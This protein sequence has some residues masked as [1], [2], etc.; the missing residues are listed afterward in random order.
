MIPFHDFRK[1]KSY[2]ESKLLKE[3]RHIKAKYQKHAKKFL[4]VCEIKA[5]PSLTQ[6]DTMDR[7][8]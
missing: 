1:A 8:A 7:G 3:T 2:Q 4:S 6:K 5:N